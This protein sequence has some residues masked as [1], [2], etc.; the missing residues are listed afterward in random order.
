MRKI[1]L[2]AIIMAVLMGLVSL[3]LNA[4][5]VSKVITNAP[6]MVDLQTNKQ[7]N[8]KDHVNKTIVLE[9]FE[10]RCSACVRAIPEINKFYES[11]QKDTN[12]SNKVVFYSVASSSSG[13]ESKVKEFIKEKGIKYPVLYDKDAYLAMS[14]S[15]NFIPT[16]VIVKEGKVVYNKVGV[17]SANNLFKSL[18]DF[19]K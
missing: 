6:T 14:F 3:V 7:I 18:M 16:L 13:N 10:T 1:M 11:I 5:D 19:V 9:F 15:V 8:L 12:V 17:E 4:K 2:T